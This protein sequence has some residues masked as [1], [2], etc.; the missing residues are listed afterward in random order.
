MDNTVSPMGARLLKR[1]I[2]MPLK[3]IEKINERLNLVAY[4]I[5]EVDLRNKLIQHIRQCGDIERLV[6][7]IPL[8]KINPREVLQIARGLQALETSGNADN[9]V[10]VVSSD[11]GYHLGQKLITG[12][13]TLWERSTRVPLLFAGPGVVDPLA[14]RR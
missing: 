4:F 2:V 9:T 10:V 14:N 5:R 1:W 6:S 3:D 11:H 13:N 8:K 12:K 7:K